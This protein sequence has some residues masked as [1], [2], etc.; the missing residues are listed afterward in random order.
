MNRPLAGGSRTGGATNPGR[1][2]TPHIVPKS[3]ASA[4]RARRIDQSDDHPD[5][6]G[7][8]VAALAMA[9]VPLT[10]NHEYHHARCPRRHGHTA[11]RYAYKGGV[12]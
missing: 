9:L 4:M 8:P 3:L 6:R 12:R 10:R 2:S 5:I 7:V 1:N 11:S